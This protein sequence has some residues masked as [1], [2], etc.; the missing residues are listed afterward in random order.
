VKLWRLLTLPGYALS[1]T[2]RFACLALSAVAVAFAVS[3]SL[4]THVATL[5]WTRHAGQGWALLDAFLW[6][7]LT[8][9]V[10]LARD[11]RALRLPALERDAVAS[12]CLYGA[13]TVAAPALLLGWTNGHLL[14]LAI[15][16]LFGAGLG[17]SYALLPPYLGVF[18]LVAAYI[19]SALSPW[20][21]QPMQPGFNAWAGPVVMVLWLALAWRIR[22]LLRGG[23]S[24]QR[25]HGPTL[26]I[27]KDA[28][29]AWGDANA[30]RRGTAAPGQGPSWA[31][32][33]VDLRGCGPGHAERSL[34]VAL[35]GWW[36]PQT[37]LGRLLQCV[38]LLAGIFV[39]ALILLT[40][41]AAGRHDHAGN[42]VTDLGAA[43]SVVLFGTLMSALLAIS[44]VRSLYQR[45]SRANAELPLLALLP[46]LGT[47]SA[48]KHAL[49][50]ASLLPAFGAQ[51]GLT[52]VLL[53]LGGVMHLGAVGETVLL[54]GPLGSCMFMGV[55]ALV[56]FGAYPMRGWS[57]ALATGAGYLWICMSGVIVQSDA[58]P[59]VSFGHAALLALAI[60]WS[61]FFVAL[62]WLGRRGWRALQ[63]RPHPFLVS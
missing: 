56:V 15:M 41:A 33:E 49:L 43:G 14:T 42:L 30:N 48:V 44:T 54:L 10:L 45:W 16:L 25:P 35:G 4:W 53:A 17:A 62:L 52:L 55:F 57:V 39:G 13:L 31:R 8:N 58:R 61:V 60:G 34:R 50:R 36:M 1:A 24:L 28:R 47:R 2:A 11:A 3:G 59:A 19:P 18:A 63:Q 51:L 26:A 40:Q 20:L 37:R 6:V 32:P 38:L 5:H 21:A 9:T 12:L 46:R 22:G 23:H 27:F 29:W 7:L